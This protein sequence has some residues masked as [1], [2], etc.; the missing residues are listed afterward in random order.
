M[1]S[2]AHATPTTDASGKPA[3]KRTPYRPDVTDKAAREIM[4]A[5]RNAQLAKTERLRAA[6][7]A[8][9]AAEPKVVQPTKRR[10]G[11]AAN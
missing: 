4:A 8:A 10:G 11:K 3:A 2:D 9:A 5:E 1:T 7:L 6:R